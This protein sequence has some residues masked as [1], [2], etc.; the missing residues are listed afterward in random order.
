MARYETI[1]AED[2][3]AEQKAAAEVIAGS[4]GSVRGPFHV[5]LHNPGLASI[6]EAF[7]GYAR[8][9]NSLPDRLNELAV[10]ICGRYWGAHVEWVSHSALALKA[11]IDQAVIDALR[12]GRTPNFAK[13]DEQLIYDFCTGV[14]DEQQVDDA[15]YARGL[16]L[17]GERGLIDLMATLTHYTVVSLTLNAFEVPVA[18]DDTP[19]FGPG[20]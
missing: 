19:P 7:G 3:T 9:K 8:F 2:Y 5:L 20:R 13:V 18:A 4:R 1:A 11:G 12:D 15:T 10:T 14:L 16:E 6:A 17:L